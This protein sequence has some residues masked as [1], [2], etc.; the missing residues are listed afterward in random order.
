VP[1]I[2]LVEIGIPLKGIKNKTFENIKRF[3][4]PL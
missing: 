2:S 1:D 3:G 4:P